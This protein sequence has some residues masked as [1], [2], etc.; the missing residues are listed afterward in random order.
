MGSSLDRAV[1][2]AGASLDFSSKNWKR[3]SGP[4]AKVYALEFGMYLALGILAG[5]IAIVAV[6]ALGGSAPGALDPVLVIVLLI[7]GL[8]IVALPIAIFSRAVN[9]V[10]FRMVDSIERGKGGDV[11]IIER[12]RGMFAPVAVY[13]IVILGIILAVILVLGALALLV[14][15]WMPVAGLVALPVLMVIAML[16]ALAVSFFF[17]FA[18]LEIALGGAGGIEALRRSAS[19][20]RAN[21][22]VTLIFDVI[23]LCVSFA[24][25]IAFSVV[26]Q[27]IG[28]AFALAAII[29]GL[30]IALFVLMI[31]I[32][33][34]QALAIGILMVPMMY[35][36]WKELG[37]L[38]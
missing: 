35:R 5:V 38:K 7:L 25:G 31:A 13:S 9:L 17:Q 30:F 4:L 1:S 11:P 27:V 2:V 32:Y 19:M 21:L 36:F 33:F 23:V 20:V 28:F 34:V 18:P 29:P 12:A 37:G 14:L 6:F 8:I 3:L 24:V 22:A 26:T 10:S 15:S 16:F